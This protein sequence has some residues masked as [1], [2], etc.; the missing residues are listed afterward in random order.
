[1]NLYVSNQLSEG[2]NIF[3]HLVISFPHLT[4]YIYL[5]Y[6]YLHHRWLSTHLLSLSF[7]F[8]NLIHEEFLYRIKFFIKCHCCNTDVPPQMH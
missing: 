2:L 5:E 1:M 8:S 7:V 6:L 4:T 3:K